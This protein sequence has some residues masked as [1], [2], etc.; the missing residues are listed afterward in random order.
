MIPIEIIDESAPLQT[1]VLG[2]AVSFG[3]EPTIDEA[4]DPKSIEHIK[5]GTFPKEQD[6]I[7]QLDEVHK[8]FERYDVEVYRPEVVAN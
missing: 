8:I 7:V 6:L 2:T 3:G 4:Y 5:D 1:V